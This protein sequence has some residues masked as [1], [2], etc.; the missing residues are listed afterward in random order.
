[1]FALSFAWNFYDNYSFR[2][3][4]ICDVGEEAFRLLHQR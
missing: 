2:T 4:S 1:M 3:L